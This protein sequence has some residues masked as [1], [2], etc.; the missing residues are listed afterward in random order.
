MALHRLHWLLWG[1]CATLL[2]ACQSQPAAEPAPATVAPMTETAV[3]TPVGVPP[4]T[5]VATPVAAAA[6]ATPVVDWTTVAGVEGD[7]YVL[8]NP[9][10]PVRLIDYSDFL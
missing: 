3:V 6:T 1:L 4:A 10:A 9:N 7:L 8:G 2:T 5:L